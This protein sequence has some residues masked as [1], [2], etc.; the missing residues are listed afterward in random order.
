M[1]YKYIK[2]NFFF[3]KFFS[4]NKVNSNSLSKKVGFITYDDS[5]CGNCTG[6]IHV[7]NI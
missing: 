4:L 7:K 2:K 6:L 5:L 1:K 3:K